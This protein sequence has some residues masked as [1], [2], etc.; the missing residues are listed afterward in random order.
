[1]SVKVNIHSS[2]R[3]YTGNTKTVEVMGRTVGECLDD[4]ISRFPGMKKVL[5][6]Q[7]GK[8]NTLIEIYLNLESTYPEELEKPVNDGDEIQITLM[9]AGG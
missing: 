2:H 3:Q 7:N 4:L 8:L 1:M 5:Y 9:L 6:H